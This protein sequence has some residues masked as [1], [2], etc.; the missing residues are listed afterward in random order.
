MKLEKNHIRWWWSFFFVHIHNNTWITH[1][2][3]CKKKS[4]SEEVS[5]NCFWSWH[6]FLF[7]SVQYSKQ[8]S[9]TIAYISTVRNGRQRIK[10]RHQ[11]EDKSAF[12]ASVEHVKN[13]VKCEGEI[14][15]IASL[16]WSSINVSIRVSHSI[17]SICGFFFCFNTSHEHNRV[18]MFMANEK[19]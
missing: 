12:P 5:F 6:F 10:N 11:K 13:W 17:P 9:W 16:S 1:E 19:W 8:S 18:A 4:I 15:S 2:C 14:G 7:S 3:K